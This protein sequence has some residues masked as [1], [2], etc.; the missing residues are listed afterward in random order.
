MDTLVLDCHY[1]LPAD[2]KLELLDVSSAGLHATGN[3]TIQHLLGLSKTNEDQYLQDYQGPDAVS[4]IGGVIWGHNARTIVPL[5]LRLNDKAKVV[6]FVV[7]PCCP[8]TF[9]S[10]EV[11]QAFQY[12]V[13]DPQ[14]S[15]NVHLNG[16]SCAVV[17]SPDNSH[18]AEV[19][20]LG[21][22][23]L[24]RFGCD[25]RFY[26]YDYRALLCIY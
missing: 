26:Y 7:A 12:E 15:I 10:R 20:V 2:I 8:Y 3:G 21:T 16:R 22:D 25:V 11:L 5:D 9:V 17:M 18:F 23:F 1:P 4:N 13:Q 24:A 19:N 14:R 6:L